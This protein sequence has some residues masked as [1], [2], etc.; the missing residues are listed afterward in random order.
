MLESY[1]GELYSRAEMLLEGRS[2]NT[3]REKVAI[4][5]F[6]L[7]NKQIQVDTRDTWEYIANIIFDLGFIDTAVDLGSLDDVTISAF[8]ECLFGQAIYWTAKGSETAA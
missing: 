6:R 3:F 5:T 7:L 2:A 8:I 4:L 1:Q